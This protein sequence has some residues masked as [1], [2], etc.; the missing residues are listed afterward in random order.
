MIN[1]TRQAKALRNIVA[2]LLFVLP[3]LAQAQLTVSV[4]VE[5]SG[6]TVIEN[7]EQYVVLGG[8]P[9]INFNFT[10]SAP[11]I[12]VISASGN[13]EFLGQTHTVRTN[14]SDG[15][16]SIYVL[17]VI[18]ESDL[19]DRQALTGSITYSYRYT[20]NETD[21]EVHTATATLQSLPITAV[22][23]P[24]VEF[25]S[26]SQR[27]LLPG[28]TATAVYNLIGG[29]A[30]SF[31]GNDNTVVQRSGNTLTVTYTATAADA[32]RVPTFSYNSTGNSA[33]EGWNIPGTK[34]IPV[35]VY[36]TP[37]VS[38]NAPE[39]ATYI[40]GNLTA[41]L[42]PQGG[43]PAGWHYVW[44]RRD[45]GGS[46]VDAGT[47]NTATVAGSAF[48]SYTQSVLTCRARNV[49]P[50]GDTLFD[51]NYDFTFTFYE[52]PSI[53]ISTDERITDL[54]SG[55]P[56]T[57]TSTIL[58]GAPD[59]WSYRWLVN[60]SQIA[61]TPTTTYTPQTSRT[62]G[63]EDVNV[64]FS[65]QNTAENIENPYSGEQ[66]RR[67]RLWGT[68]QLLS[69]TDHD[70]VVF[71]GTEVYY[72]AQ[73]VGGVEG[74]WTYTLD[75][76]TQL[77]QPNNSEIFVNTGSGEQVFTRTISATNEANG[78]RVFSDTQTFTIHVWPVPTAAWAQTMPVDV[79]SGSMSTW[80]FGL[81]TGGGDPTAWSYYWTVGGGLIGTDATAHYDFTYD[82]EG[83]SEQVLAVTATN[84]PA[85]IDA[86][87]NV[88]L[89]HTFHVWA[90]PELV[91]RTPERYTV[92]SE[93]PVRMGAT[94]KG[95][96]ADN[97]TYSWYENDILI[98]D[99]SNYFTNTSSASDR[100]MTD[101]FSL[102]A[103]NTC[104]GVDV[105]TETCDFTI[106]IWPTPV[107]EWAGEYPTNVINGVP[108]QMST[109]VS[110]GDP[111]AWTY[112]W[113]LDGNQAGTQA[114]Y[115]FTPSNTQTSGSLQST[116][117]L[118]AVNAPA[119]IDAP[120]GFDLNHTFTV[121]PTPVLAERSQ[122]STTV[123]SG[124]PVTMSATFNGGFA[125]GWTYTWT[126]DG[127]EV[128]SG[129]S[130]TVT[131]E[132]N[133]SAMTTAV[134]RL[135]AVNVCEGTEAFRQSY[136]YTVNTWPAPQMTWLGDIETVLVSGKTVDMT[137]NCLG[138]DPNAWSYTWTLDGST[139]GNDTHYTFTG[140]NG[141]E[142]GSLQASVTLQAVNAP[143]NIDQAREIVLSHTFTVWPEPKMPER[144]P[145][146]ITIYSGRTATLSASFTG[147]DTEGWSYAWNHD[148]SEVGHEPS[149]TIT[150]ENNGTS[151]SVLS[152]SL[153]AA[154]TTGKYY[155]S[156]NPS[157]TVNV[158][159]A[160]EANIGTG[161]R[162]NIVAGNTQTYN[163]VVTGGNPD[164]W[165]YSWKLDGVEVAT[166]REYTY[167]AVNDAE[168]GSVEHTLSFTATNNT[169]AVNPLNTYTS[170]TTHTFRTWAAPAFVGRSAETVTVFSGTQVNINASFCGGVEGGWTYVW[171]R[172]DT[173][174]EF[175]T[176]IPDYGFITDNTG[177]GV[178]NRVYT[179]TAVNT[180]EGTEVFR[181]TY[182]YT[183]NIWPVASTAW[184]A[185]YPTN[186]INGIPVQMSTANSGGDPTAWSYTWAENEN[187]SAGT[188]AQYTFMPVNTQ[189]EGG[190]G[191]DVRVTAVNSPAGIDE[192]YS[193]QLSH[194]F[195]AWPTPALV[196]RTAETV[197]VFSGTE[198]SLGAT[199]QGG[200]EDSWTYTWSCA[201]EEV[202]S[203]TDTYTFVADNTGEGVQTTV[204]TLTAVSTCEGAEVFRQT[205]D[206]TVNV[207]PGGTVALAE[208]LRANMVNGENQTFA[209]TV[210][211][212]DPEAWS[213][214]WTV[215]GENAGTGSTY[216]FA[217]VN[218]AETGTVEYNIV[219][220][221]TNRPAGI[222]Q[223][224]VQ[225]ASFTVTVW[226]TANVT[227]TMGDVI[228]FSGETV[229][230]VADITGGYESGWTYQWTNERGDIIGTE[231]SCD[232]T[233]NYDGN[234]IALYQ[235]WLRAINTTDGYVSYDNRVEYNLGVWENAHAS[236]AGTLPSDVISGY[237]VEM[238]AAISGGDSSHWTYQWTNND[239]VVSSEPNY[240]F[241]PENNNANG[242]LDAVVSLHAVNTPPGIRTPAEFDLSHT[243]HVWPQPRIDATSPE[244]IKVC[245]DEPTVLS[246]TVGGGYT[247]GWIYRWSLDGN[248]VGNE[249]TLS[250]SHTNNSREIET[251]RYSC[252]VV[253]YLNETDYISETFNFDVQ[254][255]P[256]ALVEVVGLN[257]ADILEGSTNYMSVNYSGGDPDAW[258]VSWAVDGIEQSKADDFTFT[259]PTDVPAEG[260][261]CNVSV[262]VTNRPASE[263]AQPYNRTFVATYTVWPILH[264]T[265]SPRVEA[266][267]VD[268]ET[269]RMGID[270]A[271]GLPTGWTYEWT[272]DG[273]AID[274]HDAYFETAAVCP[275]G[276]SAILY[277]Y[278]VTATNSLST[279][280][281]TRNFDITVYPEPQGNAVT[282]QLAGYAGSRL[283][284]QINYSM[285]NPSGWNF[286]WDA[287][288]ETATNEWFGDHGVATNVF[289]V[290]DDV[291]AGQQFTRSVLITNTGEGRTWF[292]RNIIFT[293]TAYSTGSV[294]I[295]GAPD[296]DYCG[297]AAFTIAA[298]TE[299]GYPDGW[300][301][302]WFVDGM[303]VGNDRTL[304]VAEYYTGDD[305]RA[306]TLT[307]E[308]SNS[309]PDGTRGY[310]DAFNYLFNI[311]PQIVA[312]TD[313]YISNTAIRQGNSFYVELQPTPQGGYE[314]GWYYDW[315]ENGRAIAGDSYR[316]QAA[317]NLTTDGNGMATE[318]LNYSVE[319]AN[320][321]RDW[322]SQRFTAP[323]MTVYRRPLTPASLQRKGNGNTHTLIVMMGGPTDAELT[324]L[325]YHYVF[326][327]TD[328]QGEDH[329]F[330]A[331]DKRYLQID[332]SVFDDGR[333]TLWVMTQWNYSDGSVVTS[334]RRF[335]DGNVDEEFDASEYVNGGRGEST[336]G[337]VQA[338]DGIV[339]DGR[340]FICQPAAPS[341]ANVKI[342]TAAGALIRNTDYP[343]Q[344]SFCETID[345]DALAA[346]MYV[347]EITVGELHK[348]SK[349][350]VDYK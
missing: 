224:L 54:I 251:H 63:S 49:A 16:L 180:C 160:P 307:L 55:T 26:V 47:A 40:P 261:Q 296:T 95:G 22:A 60:G 216:D 177:E 241:T 246:V 139:V 235:Y 188:G 311:W 277:R 283:T 53:A 289:V 196:E 322:F 229:T 238:A 219:L 280:S 149:L 179:L 113:S 70:I 253:N 167:R 286:E 178:Q 230:L 58:G 31:T 285:G 337:L 91:E 315:T 345:V 171:T 5:S 61:T 51:Q 185:E 248:P 7:G 335:L 328:A 290:P 13:A 9:A 66:T 8:N 266:I 38:Y 84:T 127:A 203:A 184:A 140:V 82:G 197:T 209:A 158:W 114:T 330:P 206:Y 247:P 318:E 112:A 273:F 303:N 93:T 236:L 350:V 176:D 324:S 57:F 233:P 86:A 338:G 187:Q 144:S 100:M 27:Y 142:N 339:S 287:D 341:T 108:V 59:G 325:G 165:S 194:G 136:D 96:V 312:P 156:F 83:Y 186:V 41:T 152:Y 11:G 320:A 282:R 148:G 36:P 46:A 213:Y 214:Q 281:Y 34:I 131:P 23:Y 130:L 220:T 291:T 278:A 316:Y 262:T 284:M 308:V 173:G 137:P 190:I 329:F 211:G 226:P 205:N 126:L 147:G 250:V 121:W 344:S 65:A 71:S 157:Y 163:P 10:V 221:A 153:T 223:E 263:T 207:W 2:A 110:G 98:G 132:N 346:G 279:V 306:V 317:A 145:E 174:E 327:Y 24:D 200:V 44:S 293:I 154:N 97:W 79:I 29:R 244:V 52:T 87:R 80:P 271:G 169:E 164:Q 215:N 292:Y 111:N 326:G 198:V 105:F 275:E 124:T 342:F 227:N 166:T 321:R 6:G 1:L 85:N 297:S 208:G 204:Y 243:F 309:L 310:A 88:P 48:I 94:F 182:D 314:N 242:S 123:F 32:G 89:S 201:G 129:T 192:T 21:T 73:Y 237:E 331:T 300:Q 43:D 265:S 62:S 75:N 234:A 294:T 37:S 33:G 245:S 116:V 301:F 333:N 252:W 343:R 4:Q 260:R 255:Y 199:F 19:F 150:P 92:F 212:G 12:D 249:A 334:G 191:Y 107:I 20:D 14:V 106:N 90:R 276:Y 218:T 30:W 348:I 267:Y 332:R 138:G 155:S 68:P 240:S 295:T 128:G 162:D 56:Y 72:G 172:K 302:G 323:T 189:P 50:N 81:V 288:P 304:D 269:M 256:Q 225:T 104:E 42:T 28:Q 319:A 228:I 305:R 217:A 193:Y 268:G 69:T 347:V 119:D 175:P 67:Y 133:G 115:T 99:F 118:H 141:Q 298:N 258:S 117:A 103:V 77:D 170:T 25:V 270:V 3:A 231:A 257:D 146:E 239:N 109:R 102:K 195:V 78:E 202:A 17:Q 74:G 120:R 222:D 259:A 274:A 159:P 135:T 349:V 299:G 45:N 210:T 183:V 15:T 35:T 151:M 313:I 143:A 181:Q 122:E 76:D 101:R 168:E 125:E 18:L 264:C 161:Y 272:L 64:Q 254:V 340:Y 134:Y 232:V 39:R 336:I